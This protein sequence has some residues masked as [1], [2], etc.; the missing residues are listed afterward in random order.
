MPLRI[1]R[2]A[3]EPKSH[4]SGLL[5]ADI[6]SQKI[7]HCPEFLHY[8]TAPGVTSVEPDEAGRH[9]SFLSV[10]A[11]ERIIPGITQRINTV[12]GTQRYLAKGAMK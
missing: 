6:L 7:C 9:Q 2:H 8:A 5:E 4:R 12:T 10:G 1:E 3:D 11:M